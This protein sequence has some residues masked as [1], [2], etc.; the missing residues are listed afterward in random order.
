[1]EAKIHGLKLFRNSLYKVA[2]KSLQEKHPQYIET[3]IRTLGDTGNP[4][5][6]LDAAKTI[7]TDVGFAKWRPL[8]TT[9]LDT[10]LAINQLKVTLELLRLTPSKGLLIPEGTE[11]TLVFYYIHTWVFWTDALLERARKLIKKAVRAL[12]RPNNT[13]WQSI[14]DEVSK[15]INE[16]SKELREKMRNPLA[17]GGGAG[18]SAPAEKRLW[19]GLTIIAVVTNQYEL[20]INQMLGSMAKYHIKWYESLDKKSVLVLDKIDRAIGKLNEHTLWDKI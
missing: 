18:V 19:E 10:E 3:L 13:N 1:M 8:L 11:G 15:P 16:L 6:A 20:S 9:T 4:F 17:H 5:Q 2:A 7:P 14:E 12:V